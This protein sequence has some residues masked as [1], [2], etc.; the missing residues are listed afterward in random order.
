MNSSASDAGANDHRLEPFPGE[1]QRAVAFRAVELT[2]TYAA[3][4]RSGTNEKSVA[5]RLAVE[6]FRRLDLT[7]YVGEMV[8]IVGESGAGKSSLL[9]LLAA[10]D[11]PTEGEVWFG[12]ERLSGM[13]SREASVFRNRRVGYVWQ[14]HYL[15]PEFTALENVA[16]PLMARGVS[17]SASLEQSA[18]WLER[19][20]LGG[21]EEHR[22]GELSGGEQ[23]RVSLARALVTSPQ[24]LLADEPTGDLDGRTA[25][26]IFELIQKLH[27]NHGLTSVL[28]THNLEIAGRCDRMLRLKDG[29]L[30]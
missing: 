29:V 26:T 10:L 28:V 14:F 18:V 16:L 11:R 15:L 5:G 30:V 23:Q 19:V 24:V 20:G 13:S 2:K 22:S 6:L 8:S 25:E 17:R 21:R 4:A 3:L 27:I 9:H 12:D 1:W 7:V